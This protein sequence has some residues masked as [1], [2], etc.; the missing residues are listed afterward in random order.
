VLYEV[1]TGE[2]PYKTTTA[3]VQDLQQQIAD[4]ETRKPS[5]VETLPARTRRR[6]AGDIDNIVLMALHKDVPRRYGSAEQLSEDIRRHL[7][8]LPVQARPDSVAYRAGKFVGR[9]RLAVASAAVLAL[10]LVLGVIA[11]LWEARQADLQRR[12]AE[13]RVGQLVE[14][15]NR[16]LFD[17]HGAIERLPGAT[18]ARKKIVATTLEYLDQLSRETGDDPRVQLALASAYARLAE[19]RGNP[20]VP[21]LG[22]WTGA[23]ATYQKA[24]RILDTLLARE[25]RHPVYLLRRAQVSVGLTTSLIMF[26][27][28][29]EAQPEVARGIAAAEAFLAIQPGSLEGRKLDAQLQHDRLT[30]LLEQDPAAA[31]RDAL[32]LLPKY[33]TLASQYPNDP[34]VITEL[35]GAQITLGA[36]ASLQNRRTESLA[37]FH[38]AAQLLET[39]NR[40]HPHDAV[41]Q[42]DLLR[43]YSRLAANLDASHA[44][45]EELR[46]YARKAERMA[47]SLRA[48]DPSDFMLRF[49]VAQAYYSLGN[50]TVPLA[51]VPESLRMLGEAQKIIEPMIA[52]SPGVLRLKVGLIVVHSAQ[53]EQLERLQRYREALRTYR[54]LLDVAGSVAAAGPGTYADQELA[55][56]P[57]EACKLLAMLGE[58]Q[59]S[60]AFAAKAA[61]AGGRILQRFAGVVHKVDTS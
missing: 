14:L 44:S 16:T 1:L 10:L 51:Q 48:A 56:G 61:A 23:L 34:E 22:E 9:H 27:K 21:S 57:A 54:A 28:R 8:G 15:A 17:V 49:D 20:T 11:V 47:A 3:N 12:R 40:Q 58:R 18:E 33:T 42:K 52:A 29:K 38:E 60:L 41:I 26:A 50:M 19:V 7:Q 32:R 46:Q 13:Q 35:A 30:L 4:T 39:A 53:G 45:P 24:A 2:R 5:S 55:V 59:K 37:Y 6:L 31:E 25:P 36:A 43:T